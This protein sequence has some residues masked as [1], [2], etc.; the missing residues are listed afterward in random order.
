MTGSHSVYHRLVDAGYTVI[1]LAPS[2]AASVIKETYGATVVAVDFTEKKTTF[3]QCSDFITKHLNLT[4]MQILG[5]KYGLRFDLNAKTR[6]GYLHVVRV[7]ISRTLGKWR[8]F[9]LVATPYLHLCAY[10]RRPF[11]EV[12]NQYKPALVFIPNPGSTQGEEVLREC[13]RQKVRTVGM[14]GSWDH[15]HKRFQALHTDVVFVWSE[16]LKQEMMELQSYE[17]E[18]IR[19]I[20]IPHGDFFT[21]PEYLLSREEF[22]D[23]LGLDPAMRLFTLYSGTRR[24]PDEGDIVA[25]LSQASTEGRTHAPVQVYVRTYPGD[26][27]EDHKKFDALAPL[28][29]V[30]MDWL[31]GE[32]VFGPMPVNY[33]PD[34][35]YMRKVVNTFYHSDAVLSVYSSASVEASIFGKPSINIGFD[36]YQERPFHRS[37]ARFVYQSHFDKLFATGA[38]LDTHTESELI[39]AVNRVIDD[40]KCKEREVAYL[41]E[42]VCG[43]TDGK[44]GERMF[45]YIVAL[46]EQRAS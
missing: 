43:P 4:G 1:V 9:R 11:Q 7:L 37:V 3:E 16:S 39:D 15:P 30:H 17:E 23:T 8:W 5:S 12:F 38:M 18:A 34:E 36:G 13:K 6:H 45:Q 35:E 24:A 19:I 25:M 21:H 41:R 32:K 31:L 20:G 33:F 14:V 26:R 27:E 29:H 22:F 44:A 42:R 10:R 46:I 2:Y 28:P 40:P